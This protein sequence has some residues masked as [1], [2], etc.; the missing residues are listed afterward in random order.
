MKAK[1]FV[2][3]Q[4]S[5]QEAGAALEGQINEWL[6]GV[7]GVKVGRTQLTSV[8]ASD[9]GPPLFVY[10]ILY[11]EAKKPMGALVTG[12]AKPVIKGRRA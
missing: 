8:P 1:I 11:E 10:L 12:K 2:S 9:N 4:A 3:G 7:P 6:S 5:P